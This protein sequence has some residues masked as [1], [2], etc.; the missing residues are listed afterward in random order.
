M[1]E[2]IF[3]GLILA[4]SFVGCHEKNNKILTKEVTFKKE[5]ELILKKPA[6]IPFWQI[7]TLKLLIPITKH[8]LD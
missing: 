1:K 7:W 4:S 2:I 5:G 6:T 8:K 3:S